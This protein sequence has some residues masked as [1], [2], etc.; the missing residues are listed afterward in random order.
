[1]KTILMLLISLFS[2]FL[3][4]QT[5]IAELERI[6]GVWRKK[7]E[8]KPFTG[9]FI[10]KFSNGKVKGTGFLEN[11]ILEGER[12][13]FYENEVIRFKMFYKNGTTNGKSFEN[14]ETG[15]LKQEGHFI[16]GKENGEW[17]GY[18]P[19]GKIKVI[20]NFMNGTQQGDYFEY[21]ENGSLKAQYFFR[22]GKVG[23]SDEIMNLTEKALDLSK[24]FKYEE[25]IKLYDEAIKLNPTVAQIYFN[26][27]AVK[28]NFFDF[29][30]AIKDYDKAIEI[31]PSYMEAYGN[32]GNAKINVYTS[33]GN[34][35]PSFEQTKSACEDFEKSISLGDNTIQ[36]E[37][38]IF[39]YCRKK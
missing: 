7:G 17:R 38:N 1:M 10:E 23:Y 24:K 3:T 18:F 31:N 30:G 20:M 14:Y 8:L 37:D 32:R 15:V 11:G 26:R 13:S 33:K 29:V 12:V 4:A 25:A 2:F 5:N 19:N 21:D 9:E 36:T 28:S 39:L 27:G 22:E 16:E 34:L 35:E 6:E